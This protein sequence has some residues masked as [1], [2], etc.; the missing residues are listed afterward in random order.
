VTP[1]GGECQAQAGS[2]SALAAGGACPAGQALAGFAANGA[3]LC[4]PVIQPFSPVGPQVNVAEGELVGWTR[5]FRDTYA[6]GAASIATILT[7]CDGADLLLACRPVGASRFTVLAAA[8][9]ADVTTDTGVTN[10][11]HDANGTGWYFNDD[12]SWGFAGQGDA[13]DRISCDVES[14]NPER[15][16]C[17]HTGSGTMDAGWRCGTATDVFDGSWERVIY[18]RD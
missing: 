13:I 6:D 2:G 12:Y 5:C 7:Q 4:E 1:V 8:P 17:W 14:T 18:H 9:R 10:T 3:A 16:L 15:R 11:P